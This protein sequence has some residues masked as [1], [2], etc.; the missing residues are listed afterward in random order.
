MQRQS[1]YRKIVYNDKD[2]AHPQAT[3][4]LIQPFIRALFDGPR[5]FVHQRPMSNHEVLTISCA[6]R[7]N[8]HC[9][10]RV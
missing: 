8:S 10:R 9:H 7:N 1:L 2:K 5:S 3:E 4:S 6:L